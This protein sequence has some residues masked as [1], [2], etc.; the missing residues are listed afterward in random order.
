M[1][2]NAIWP[3]PEMA[4]LVHDSLLKR[5]HVV[6]RTR[7]LTKILS[8]DFIYRDGEILAHQIRKTKE[9]EEKT[10]KNSTEIEGRSAEVDDDQRSPSPQI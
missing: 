3:E 2:K 6:W 1:M 8:K 9:E 10:E 5:P 7:N 4:E